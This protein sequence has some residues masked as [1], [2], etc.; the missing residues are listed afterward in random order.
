MESIVLGSMA[1]AGNKINK[2]KGKPMKKKLNKRP[3]DVYDTN[4]SDKINKAV[5][6]QA[7]DTKETGYALC[8]WP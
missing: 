3:N 1:Y 6:K 2:N 8:W 7:K 4:I 5:H